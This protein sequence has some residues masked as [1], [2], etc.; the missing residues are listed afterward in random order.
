MAVSSRFQTSAFAFVGVMALAFAL[1]APAH[2]DAE[3][4]SAGYQ[5]PKTD[6]TRL[7]L[8]LHDLP[9]G[10]LNVTLREGEEDRILCSPLTHSDNTPP[11]LAK[12]IV[13][14]HPKGCIATYSRLFTVPGE[15]PTPPLIGTGVMALGN[16]KA[17]DAGWAVLSTL[18]GQLFRKG[19]LHEIET[20]VKIGDATRLFHAKKI[21]SVVGSHVTFLAW[22]SANTLATV[23]TVGAP[24]A[25]QDRLAVEFAERQQAHIDKPS[26]YT[27]AERFDGEVG[28]DDP[29]IDLPVYWLG[30]NFNP[31]NGLP[32]NKLFQSGFLGEPIPEEDLRFGSEGPEA[33]LQVNY[34]NIWL[35]TWTPAT[36]DVFAESKT[37]RVLTT[38]KCTRTR[39]VSLPGGSAT[40]FGGFDKDFKHCPTRA[41]DVF[42]AWVEVGGVTVVVNA[43]PAPDFIE[44]V[45]PYGSFK[46][47]EAIVTALK[48]RPQPAY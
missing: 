35:D 46:G 9:A 18:L 36:W 47:M 21:P 34:E 14:F 6:Q 42:S 1:T 41:P 7:I 23:M 11:Q 27:P 48:L 44:R 10:F 3:A 4:A 2:D 31:G 45:N 39:T 25:D 12:F 32:P 20:N 19:E 40:I 38:W 24:F 22:R 37:G 16:D 8:R 13:A 43:P 29:A 30:R 17:T 28:L 15:K 5:P 26:R 33:P